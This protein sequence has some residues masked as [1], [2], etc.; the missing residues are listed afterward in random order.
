MWPVMG[1]CSWALGASILTESESV[2]LSCRRPPL[3]SGAAGSADACRVIVVTLEV[4]PLSPPV[5]PSAQIAL[6]RPL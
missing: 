3:T 1:P 4:S 2:V 6:A 5:P